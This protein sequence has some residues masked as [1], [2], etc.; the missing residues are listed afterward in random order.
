[1][2]SCS[3]GGNQDILVLLNDVSKAKGSVQKLSKG[4]VH[5]ST[6]LWLLS[7]TQSTFPKSVES[8]LKDDD[9]S[10]KESTAAMCASISLF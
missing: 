3:A 4:S 5:D 7:A 1:M 8:Q 2:N 10:I 9:I 6:E